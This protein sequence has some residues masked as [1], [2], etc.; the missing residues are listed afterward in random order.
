[1]KKHITII[2]SLLFLIGCGKHD[3][4]SQQTS[5]EFTNGSDRETVVQQVKHIEQQK[6]IHVTY[7]E[8]QPNSMLVEF[9]S[10]QATNRQK[11]Q[12]HFVND[13]LTN[14]IHINQ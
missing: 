2:T 13:R 9:G 10:P 4:Q 5:I 14:T 11:V 1:M 8:Y 12:F 6:H 7:L 3:S